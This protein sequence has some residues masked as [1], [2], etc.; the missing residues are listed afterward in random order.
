MINA[1]EVEEGQ[2]EAGGEEGLIEVPLI[3][4]MLSHS[5]HAITVFR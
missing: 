1:V 4:Q 2:A 3:A 5:S